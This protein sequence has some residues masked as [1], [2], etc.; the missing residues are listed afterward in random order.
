MVLNP[1]Y[2]FKCYRGS[3]WLANAKRT[4]GDTEAHRGIP[5]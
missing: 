2:P 4:T 1:V 5:L 3:A